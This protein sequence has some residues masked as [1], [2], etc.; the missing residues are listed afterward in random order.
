MAKSDKNALVQK[1]VIPLAKA[2]EQL[3]FCV[4][5]VEDAGGEVPPDLIPEFSLATETL[6]SGVDERLMLLMAIKS[7]RAGID[8]M[9]E[10]LEEKN[11]TL[12]ALEK[13][14]KDDARAMLT[15]HPDIA[16]EGDLGSFAMQKN[17]GLQG[18]RYN[19]QI[20]PGPRDTVDR[21]TAERIAA[22][23]TRETFFVFDRARFE[24]DLR[25]G[26]GEF[27]APEDAT[28]EPR[29]EHVRVRI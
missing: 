13:R 4:R 15:A 3:A 10:T 27:I 17:G 1:P 25:S 21:E 16:L 26:Q 29:G 6:K 2:L 8:S 22:Y 11:E 18:V 14:I 7:M 5:T 24:S 28:L 20:L 9:I 23:V 19:F 12:S